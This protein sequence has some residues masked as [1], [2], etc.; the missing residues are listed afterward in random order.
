MIAR[1]FRTLLS[2]E[3][4]IGL[5]IF[6][7]SYT[8]FTRPFEG[9][10]H[11]IIFLILLPVFISRYGWSPLPF[12]F[13]V[14]PAAFGFIN[15]AIGNVSSFGFFKILIGML[16]SVTFYNYVIIHYQR[17]FSKL[18]N[19]YLNGILVCCYISIVQIVSYQIKFSP[20][21]DYSWL[22]NKWRI[23]TGSLFSLRLNSIFAEPSQF[24]L[25]LLPALFVAIHHLIMRKFELMSFFSCCMVIGCLILTT[26]STGYLGILFSF[27]L[28]AI[29]FRKIQNLFAVIGLSIV[30]FIGL[31]N[32][33]DEFRSRID[34]SVNLWTKD[35]YSLEDINSSSFVLF[36]NF[37]IAKENLAEHPLIGTGLGSYPDIYD[38]YSLTK[39]EDFL[40][41]RGFDFNSQDGNSLLIRSMA[42]IGVLGIGFW[43]VLIFKFFRKR[44]E[45]NPDDYYWLYSSACLAIILGY[46]VRQG[47][48]F[49]NGFPFFVLLYYYI[50][51]KKEADE[52]IAEEDEEE[53][54]G[55]GDEVAEKTPREL[56][57]I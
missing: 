25:M 4:L 7:S 35:K 24:A 5:S 43:I 1:Y 54:D 27:L 51:K 12:R 33:V 22:L 17:N 11:Y 15:L 8:F 19:L 18:F 40:I 30:G 29:Q 44:D 41:K 47:N 34:T 52:E 39:R 6:I 38:K 9:Y 48:Y 14:L 42:E 53:E 32:N 26:S 49:L 16:L 28:F 31:Y 46:L 50:G 3:G 37:H 13:I 2:M 21:Y 55:E 57:H 20:G 36:N 23:H 56:R 45:D 10:F